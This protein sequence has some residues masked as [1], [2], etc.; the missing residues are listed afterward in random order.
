MCTCIYT[1][2]VTPLVKKIS[3]GMKD[4][5]TQKSFLEAIT[6]FERLLTARKTPFF[7]G[8]YSCC[9]FNNDLIEKNFTAYNVHEVVYPGILQRGGGGREV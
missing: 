7:G 2:Q 4:D 6:K 5:E 1:L 9:I 3:L 8:K